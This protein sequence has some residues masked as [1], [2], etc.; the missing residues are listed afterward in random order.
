MRVNV[1]GVWPTASTLHELIELIVLESPETVRRLMFTAAM[2]ASKMS[3]QR[4]VE[5]YS[6]SVAE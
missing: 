4:M 3:G 2:S 1:C 5:N 6:V